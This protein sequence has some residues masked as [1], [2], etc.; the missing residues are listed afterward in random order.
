[1]LSDREIHAGPH[2]DSSIAMNDSVTAAMTVA[3]DCSDFSTLTFDSHVID[4][5]RSDDGKVL[6]AHLVSAY[7]VRRPLCA[8]KYPSGDS[9]LTGRLPR[10]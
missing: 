9:F 5:P 1:M 3:L 2:G 7:F 8:L 10:R 4:T 6:G